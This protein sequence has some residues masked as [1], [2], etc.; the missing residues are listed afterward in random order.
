MAA[1]NGRREQALTC[2]AYR[3]KHRL[4]LHGVV[5][6]VSFSL[7]CDHVLEPVYCL[8]MCFHHGLQSL[9]YTAVR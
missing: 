3:H 4:T 5:V 6:S 1:V 2:V 8:L 9:Y 7:F